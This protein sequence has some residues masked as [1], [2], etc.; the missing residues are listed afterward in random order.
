MKLA[1]G[2]LTLIFSLGAVAAT[3]Q[4]QPTIFLSCSGITYDNKHAIHLTVT[5][6][7]PNK[8]RAVVRSTN[9]ERIS[10]AMR[11]GFGQLIPAGSGQIFSINDIGDGNNEILLNWPSRVL[12]MQYSFQPMTCAQKGI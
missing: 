9:G 10:I 3:N 12:T 5:K 1:L 8:F 7:G 2:L 4:K 6:Q 11:H